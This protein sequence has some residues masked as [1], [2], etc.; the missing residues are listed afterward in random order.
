LLNSIWINNILPQFQ[1]ALST[2]VSSLAHNLLVSVARA[3]VN[4]ITVEA[5]IFGVLAGRQSLAH[6]F[7]DS[8]TQEPIFMD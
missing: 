3:L 8:N 2:G 1:P 6:F 4:P 5:I 7:V